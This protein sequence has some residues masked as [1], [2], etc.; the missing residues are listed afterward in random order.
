MITLKNLNLYKTFITNRG[1]ILSRNITKLNSKNN[2][3][4]KKAIKYARI[5]NLLPFVKYKNL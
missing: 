4:L 5:Q 3:K 1:K 2:K